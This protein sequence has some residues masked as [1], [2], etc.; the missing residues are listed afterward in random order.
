MAG[1]ARGIAVGRAGM[2]KF[3]GLAVVA[4]ALVASPAFAAGGGG[5]AGGAGAQNAIN[6]GRTVADGQPGPLGAANNPRPKPKTAKT[7]ERGEESGPTPP[8]R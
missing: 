8:T 6:S 1:E 4:S 7:S 2:M 3:C 5:S